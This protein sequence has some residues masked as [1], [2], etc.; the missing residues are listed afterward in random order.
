M[1]GPANPNSLNAEAGTEEPERH[2]CD[3]ESDREHCDE[4]IP[5]AFESP[6]A[7]SNVGNNGGERRKE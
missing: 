5:C 2:T 7:E 3:T 1:I 6:S 4:Q